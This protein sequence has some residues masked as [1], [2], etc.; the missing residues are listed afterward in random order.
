MSE[1]LN[2]VL[3]TVQK[4]NQMGNDFDLE[5]VDKD[6][7]LIEHGILDS[8][9]FVNLVL[10]L[11]ARTSASVSLADIDPFEHTSINGLTAFFS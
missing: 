8:L 9:G 7:S 4:M 11:E 3:E 1:I 10:E 6:V 5:A 2:V